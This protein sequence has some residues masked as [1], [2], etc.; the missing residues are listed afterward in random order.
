M[1]PGALPNHDNVDPYATT[2]QDPD[3][4]GAVPLYRIG[5]DTYTPN[6]PGIPGVVNSFANAPPGG[7]NSLWRSPTVSQSI[8]IAQHALGWIGLR[9]VCYLECVR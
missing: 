5:Y 6:Y 1:S 4:Y 2:G 8:P 7:V 3:P 9:P